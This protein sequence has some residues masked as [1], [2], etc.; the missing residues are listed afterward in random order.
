MDTASISLAKE[1][2]I[3]IL[4]FS[5]LEKNSLRDIID[6]KGKLYFDRIGCKMSFDTKFFEEKMEKSLENLK[7]EFQG[8]EPAEPLPLY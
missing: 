1:N 2:K 5:I 6:G 4:V 3:P 8:L 7:K